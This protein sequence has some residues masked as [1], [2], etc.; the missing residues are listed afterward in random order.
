MH[1]YFKGENLK[2]LPLEVFS[3]LFTMLRIRNLCR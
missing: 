1:I 2:T 3:T